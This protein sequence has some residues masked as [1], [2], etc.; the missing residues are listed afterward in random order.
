[1]ASLIDDKSPIN[2]AQLYSYDRRQPLC[3]INCLHNAWIQHKAATTRRA[4]MKAFPSS[5]VHRWLIHN[6]D[7]HSKYI[8]NIS[9][10]RH[11]LVAFY[12]LPELECKASG[13]PPSILSEST[14]TFCSAF[15]QPRYQNAAIFYAHEKTAP[16]IVIRFV[17]NVKFIYEWY[18]KSKIKVIF[19][20]IGHFF[21][22]SLCFK[23]L[24]QFLIFFT[25]YKQRNCYWNSLLFFSAYG[26]ELWLKLTF[27]IK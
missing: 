4:A 5:P 25:V 14:P 17:N 9:Q 7:A 3:A 6:T 26:N 16:L 8:Y 11:D 2:V 15:S 21:I 22:F 19:N 20:S 13:R 27:I 12:C 23:K 24:W 10:H 1:M 18:S